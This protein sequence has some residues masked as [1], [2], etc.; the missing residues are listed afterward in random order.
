MKEVTYNPFD[1]L[2]FLTSRVGRLLI[3]CIEKRSK[4]ER[5]NIV[6]SD[7]ELMVILWKKDGLSQ[8]DLAE[9]VIRDKGTITRTLTR[10]ERENLVI[11]VPDEQDKRTK[12]IYLTH[13]GKQLK[14]YLVPLAYNIISEATVQLTEEEIEVCKKVLVKMYNKLNI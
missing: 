4:I 2:V 8:Q 9:S 12:R 11:R 10:M 3:N 5:P 13:K 14:E 7:M 6:K 1:S